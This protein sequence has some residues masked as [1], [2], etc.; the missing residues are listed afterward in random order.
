MARSKSPDMSR[1]LAVHRVVIP[2]GNRADYLARLHV[3][4][5]YFKRANCAFW[6]FEEGELPGAFLEFTEAKDP[7]VLAAAMVA[8]PD[9]PPQ[10]PR[11][12][13]EVELS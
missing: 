3:R 2:S 13:T 4:K 7:H 11:I 12:Y 1:S 9:A 10:A 6:V 8:A 5:E